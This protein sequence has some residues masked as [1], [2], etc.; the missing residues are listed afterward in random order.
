ML[1]SF[2][3]KCEKRKF[4]HT[5]TYT[6]TM[7]LCKCNGQCEQYTGIGAAAM[8]MMIIFA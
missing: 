5:C 3:Y 1:I 8:D 4:M 2:A 6:C 7:Y